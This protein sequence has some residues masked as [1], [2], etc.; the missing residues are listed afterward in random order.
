MRPQRRRYQHTGVSA[1][2]AD[3]VFRYVVKGRGWRMAEAAIT[4]PTFSPRRLRDLCNG[5]DTMTE[6]A[7]QAL[8][9]PR[10]ME[11]MR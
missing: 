1:R 11:A 2:R 5:L 6:W 10:N 9:E 7:G 4:V 3:R 8:R